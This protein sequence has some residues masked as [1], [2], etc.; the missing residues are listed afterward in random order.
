MDAR[1]QIE[2]VREKWV[3]VSS[4]VDTD[5]N[6]A[7]VEARQRC[8]MCYEAYDMCRDCI[9]YHYLGQSCMSIPQFKAM[10][11]KPP[12]YVIERAV[13]FA[14]NTLDEMARNC[15]PECGNMVREG[16]GHNTPPYHCD[17]CGI[18]WDTLEIMND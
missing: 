16:D 1:D 6:L 18:G 7:A 2:A 14:L 11:G 5:L 10:K 9:A 4:L 8:K 3:Q 12:R 13:S 17:D 15:C